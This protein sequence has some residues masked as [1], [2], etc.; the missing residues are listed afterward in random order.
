MIMRYIGSFILLL[1]FL[2]LR[3]NAQGLEFNTYES[4]TIQKTSYSVFDENPLTFK[5]H[6]SISYDL[7]IQDYG[8]FGYIFRL[9]DLKRENADIYS[10]VFSY[11]NDERSYLKFNIE[12]KECLIVDT[13]C[14]KKLGPRRWIPIE[15]S[16]FLK[17][18]SV[19]LTIDKRQYQS[20]KLGLSGELTPT[21]MFGSSK[22]SEEIPSFAIRNLVIS[23]MNQQINFPLNESSGI[24]VHDKQGKIRGK[25]IN[26]IWLINKS[27]YW[28]LLHSQ[29]SE[30]TAGYNYDFNSGN[31]VYF[32]SDSLYTLDIRRNIWEGYKH[33]PLP[34]KM[35]LGTNFFYPDSRSVYIYEV[36]NHADVCTICALNVLTGEVEK[37]DD[38]FLPSQRHHH[39]SYLDTIRNKFYIFGGFGSRKYTNTLEVYDL[40]QKSWNTIKLKGDFVA[41]RFFSSMGALNANELLLFGGTGNSSGDQSIGKIYYYD[42]YKINLKD[43]TVQKVRDF[44]Y[45]GAQIVPVRNLLLSDDGA[46]FYTLCYPMQEASSHLQLYKFSLQNDSYEVLG[47]SIPM[48]SKAILSNANLYYNKETKEFYCCTQEFNERGGESSVTRF[49]SLSAPAIAENALFLYAVEEGLS[50]RTVIFVMVVVLILIVGITYYL[51]RKKEKQPIP[52]VAPVR[53]TFTQVE[54]KKSPQANAL[55]LFGE[56]TIID[57]K[58]RDITHLF[59][60]KIKQLFLLTFLNGLDNKE[61]ITSNYIYGLLWPEKEL[62]S[63]KNLKGVTINRLRK[64]LDDLEG[65][66][67]VY[68]NSRYSIQLSE[69]FYCDYQQYLEQMNKIRQ[70]DAS[71]EVSQSL[72]G[73]LSR[74]KFL[75]SIDD[76]MFDSFKSEQEYELHEMLTI[77]LNN[78]YMKAAYE[79][80]AQLAEIWLRVDSLNDTALWYMLNACHKLKKEDQAMKKYYLYI[81]EYNKSMGNNY[82]YS[83]SDIIHNALRTSF[84]SPEKKDCFQFISLYI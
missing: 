12:A 13:L 62:S 42:L 20:G 8:S 79:Q 84:Q 82:S 46:S 80:V 40:D 78:L 28:N 54:N 22:F 66:E 10:F 50:L 60:S 36:D 72:I 27:Y 81:A 23:D 16:F 24:L 75:K 65:I 49:Y 76:S 44:S 21:I 17:E 4:E 26:P 58:G 3:A 41:P 48:E 14:N 55:Y 29:A 18:D 6:L 59:S 57:K 32:N 9:K 68:T 2:C 35:Y 30:S 56:F 31:F 69:A 19:C 1:C 73:I 39:S 15:I 74:G 45:D 37:V 38:K 77:E 5:G 63:A 52:K 47:N 70:S 33:Q 34:M 64:I 25:A 61:G 83:Y 43:S 67:L 53:K 11:D 71:Q 7:A 51:K